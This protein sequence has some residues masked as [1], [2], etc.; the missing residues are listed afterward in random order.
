MLRYC[1]I[2]LCP[3][4]VRSIHCSSHELQSKLLKRAYIGDYTGDYYSGKKG[5]TRSLDYSSPAED[6]RNSRAF[7]HYQPDVETLDSRLHVD[8]TVRS[9]PVFAN[10]IS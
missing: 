6:L 9:R 10:I 3:L 7:S 8:S 5:D 1:G 4:T 2:V